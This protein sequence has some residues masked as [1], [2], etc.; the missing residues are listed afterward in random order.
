MVCRC[1]QQHHQ[2]PAHVVDHFNAEQHE[3]DRNTQ[4]G[5]GSSDADDQGAN[6]VGDPDHVEARANISHPNADDDTSVQP[7][8]HHTHHGTQASAD[9]NDDFAAAQRRGRLLGGCATRRAG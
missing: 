1:R 4:P 7:A 3:Y 2:A 8:H 5:P 6:E 9:N